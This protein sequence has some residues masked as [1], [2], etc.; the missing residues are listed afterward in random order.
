MTHNP[1]THRVKTTVKNPKSNPIPDNLI[2]R[3]LCATV[4]I[5]TW[6]DI[7]RL[8]PHHPKAAASGGLPCLRLIL[9]VLSMNI[10]RSP[11]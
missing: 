7:E 1:R 8:L 11:V 10:F 6:A 3:Y 4:Q 5:A 2:V 9:Q